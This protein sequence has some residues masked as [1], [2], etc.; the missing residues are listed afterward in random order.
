MAVHEITV[1]V[2]THK[3]Y[4][5]PSDGVYLPL[6]VGKS[7]HPESCLGF[8]T[9]DSGDNISELNPYFSELTGL[10]WIW[11]NCTSKY[12]GIVH[13]RRHFSRPGLF[14]TL[15]FRNGFVRIAREDDFR[16]LL[17]K[18]DII[19]PR[20]RNYVIETVYSHY[21]HTLPVEQ[22]DTT[23]EILNG[24]CPKYLKAFDE[25][26]KSRKAHMF[27][28][29]IMRDSLMNEYCSWLFPIL[30]ELM[31]CIDPDKYDAF[32]ARYPGR[33]SE[34]LLDVWLNT[35]HYKYVE[36]PTVS[37]EPVNWLKKGAGFLMAKFM[38][39]KYTVSC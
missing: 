37:P 27:N 11:K 20:P 14:N 35:N 15:G 18:Y 10:Y 12:K 29:F 1:A 5:M 26:M 39:K 25:Q 19:V 28:M 16:S 23:R 21:A 17:K 34:I 7:A 3:K 32:N 30:D 8:E 9:D 13:Y 36:M 33:I 24:F 38:G 22:L 6:Q 2:A 31:K 4:R